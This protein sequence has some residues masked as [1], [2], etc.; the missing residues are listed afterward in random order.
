MYDFHY[1]RPKTLADAVGPERVIAAVDSKGGQVVIHGWKTALPITAVEAVRAL[2]PFC[3]EFLYTHVDAEGMMQGTNMPAILAVRRATGNR[4]TA[5]G[6]ITTWAEIDALDADEEVSPALR[7]SL[8]GFFAGTPDRFAGARFPRKVWFIDRWITHGDWYPDH[9]LRLFHRDRARWGGDDFVH[10]KVVCQGPVATLRG[11]LHH[12]SFPTLA[13]HVGKIA[14][15]AELFVNA[16]QAKGGRF[17][18]AAAVLRPAWRFFRAYV[19]RRG[20]L[21]G[22]P[23]LWIAVATAGAVMACAMP[24]T[25]GT[26]H[27]ETWSATRWIGARLRCACATSRRQAS[28]V[29]CRCAERSSA[30]IC[31]T[32]RAIC[33]TTLRM[34][35]LRSKV[36][37]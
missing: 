17:S 37:R 32:F 8:H 25:A 16:Q 19:L 9:S 30:R 28:C 4:V 27:A 13:S 21:D 14:P 34:R 12:Y 10:E 6:G 22:F 5:A 2:E 1:H 36:M 7:E 33:L 11:D 31:R 29:R 35:V 18:L 3:G 20:F 26:N 15:F 23:G 24:S